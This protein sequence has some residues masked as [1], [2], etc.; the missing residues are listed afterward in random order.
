MWII[1]QLCSMPKL[2]TE[3][4][5]LIESYEVYVENDT[6]QW[7]DRLYKCVLQGKW[8]WIVMTDQIGCNL[9]WKPDKTTTWRFRHIRSMSKTKFI[10]HDLS[11]RVWSMMKT[12]QDMI[13]NRPLVYAKIKIEP[14]GPHLIGYDLWWKLDKTMTWPIIQVQSTPKMILNFRDWLD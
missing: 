6:R 4:S 2:K 13:D 11:D 9:W 5:W 7:H 14:S 10:Y 1:V 3:L 12:R 8:Y